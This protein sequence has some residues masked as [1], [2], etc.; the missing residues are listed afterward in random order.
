[1]EGERVSRFE[2]L[3]VGGVHEW[4]PGRRTCAFTR[5]P[6]DVHP[7]EAVIVAVRLCSHARECR[8]NLA[9]RR[10]PMGQATAS[11]RTTAN[12][13]ERVTA[14]LITTSTYSWRVWTAAGG[15][16][17]NPA[18]L[19]LAE[20]GISVFGRISLA[21]DGRTAAMGAQHGARKIGHS[22][23][24]PRWRN[25]DCNDRRHRSYDG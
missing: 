5:P 2:R 14:R 19:S 7:N 3:G 18:E 25:V 20:R 13:A 4:L 8:T 9:P 11:P 16:P 6:D 23:L 22:Q 1:M 10:S 15:R 21:A 24:R 12:T 17:G